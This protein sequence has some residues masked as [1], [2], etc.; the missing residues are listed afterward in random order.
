M[1]R[2]LMKLWVLALI[3]LISSKLFD[4]CA[5]DVDDGV[6]RTH[7]LSSCMTP[8][9]DDGKMD[10]SNLKKLPQVIRVDIIE[11]SKV[12]IVVGQYQSGRDKLIP[13]QEYVIRTQESV[14]LI[15]NTEDKH[16]VTSIFFKYGTK[17]KCIDFN[18][19][20]DKG[21]ISISDLSSDLITRENGIYYLITPLSLFSSE[22]LKELP[23][24]VKR[25]AE[26]FNFY[27][28]LVFQNLFLDGCNWK[29]HKE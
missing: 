2:F 20:D 28:S 27:E 12:K 23:A 7:F 8:I 6:Y 1:N 15:D 26:N 10:K 16:V 4:V 17:L 13:S 11:D 22:E 25:E 9:K 19:I 3:I 24:S 14:L 29:S 21:Y 18:A 5:A